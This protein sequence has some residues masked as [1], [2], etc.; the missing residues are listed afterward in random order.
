MPEEGAKIL[1]PLIEEVPP[2]ANLRQPINYAEFQAGG[3]DGS[4]LQ[5]Y[6]TADFLTGLPDEA[7]DIP[8]DVCP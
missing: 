1:A 2:A 4:G 6:W 5:N 3:P 8:R 7:I